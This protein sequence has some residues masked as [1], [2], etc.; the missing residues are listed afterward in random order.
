VAYAALLESE[1][2][3][4]T[5]KFSHGWDDGKF[6]WHR[7]EMVKY[8]WAQADRATAA[9]NASRRRRRD[10]VFMMEACACWKTVAQRA[11]CMGRM[12]RTL[13]VC[14]TVMLNDAV[15][16]QRLRIMVIMSN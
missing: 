16:Y 5:N 11:P 10:V 6:V 7:F 9:D 1:W 3:L 12:D 8:D 13:R 2:M 14:N 15:A 4:R